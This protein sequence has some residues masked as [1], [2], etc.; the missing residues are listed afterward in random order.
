MKIRIV[1]IK[2]ERLDGDDFEHSRSCSRS[3]LVIA[4][5]SLKRFG[6]GPVTTALKRDPALA[7]RPGL[8]ANGGLELK[9]ESL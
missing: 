6:R 9:S 8:R 5:D 1:S 4:I 3:E 7:L 2:N